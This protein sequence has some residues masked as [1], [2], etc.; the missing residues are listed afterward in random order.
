MMILVF[1]YI[2]MNAQSIVSTDPSN[3]NVV[4]EEYTGI[5]CG[6]CPD[7]H[8][9]AKA[10][11]DKFPGRVVVINIH[12]GSYANP[13]SGSGH[14]DFRTTY[15]PDLLSK[16]GVAGFP[17]GTINREVFT[18]G[19]Y[20]QQQPPT[21]EALSRGGWDPAGSVV[22]GQA[23]PV[24]VGAITSWNGSTRELT[25]DVELYY[26]DNADA[27]N[28]LNVVF[29]E[30]GYVG[31]QGGSAE[32]ANYVHN[33][34]LRHMLTGTWGETISTTT[35][36]TLVQKTYKY[37]VPS[38]YD[39]LE[40]DIAVFVTKGNN[41]FV[42]T[43]IKVPAKTPD[44]VLS[45]SGDMIAAKGNGESFTKEYTIRNNSNA[46]MTFDVVAEKSA[47]TPGDWDVAI[48]NNKTEITVAA[49][50]TGTFSVMITAGSSS[51]MGDAEIMVKE[52][53]AG[54]D[55]MTSKFSVISK[56]VKYLDIDLEAYS[57]YDVLSKARTGAAS[58]SVTDFVAVG[59]DLT[60][61]KV[62]IWNAAKAQGITTAAADLLNAY[63]NSNVG[64]VI[65]GS[66]AVPFLYFA[67]ANNALLGTLGISYASGNDI[68][69]TAF[70]LTGI[71]GDPITDGLSYPGLDL[72]ASQYYLQKLNIAN[73]Q[74]AFPILQVQGGTNE[75]VAVR[76]ETGMARAVVLGFNLPTLKLEAQQVELLK[77]SIDW[78][79][80][81]V[82]TKGPEISVNTS[83][84]EF[85]SVA[86]G[87]SKEESFKVTNEGDEDLVI[88]TMTFD[89]EEEGFAFVDLPTLPITI[90]PGAYIDITVAFSPVEEREYTDVVSIKSNAIS[91]EKSVTVNGIG[92]AGSNGAEISVNVEGIEFGSVNTGSSKEES[93]K[94]TND[95]NEN[96]VISSM[97]FDVE[98]AFAFV[99]M[100]SLPI[101]IEP[102]AFIDLTVAFTP[103]MDIDYT[104]EITIT[105]NAINGEKTVTLN[106][107]GTVS[108]VDENGNYFTGG[109][110]MNAGPNP[111]VQ[112]TQIRY[113]VTGNSQN[114]HIYIV[115]A[116]GKTVKTLVNSVVET[117]SYNVGFDGTN[118]SSG[119][120]FVVSVIDGKT[121]QMPV[122]LAK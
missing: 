80:G 31:Y 117:G 51:G 78:I 120:Y 21:G 118:L 99:G 122:V 68:Q 108:S 113:N 83:S 105:S 60:A 56:N 37:T 1:T 112:S 30:N 32:G 73:T 5:Y 61:L 33:K 35:K 4:L 71:A 49:G 91:G 93:F 69:K 88:T 40:C 26:T 45:T 74:K 102:G 94:I 81:S 70:T 101:T 9:R 53:I 8:V 96:L 103:T 64:V 57:M 38:E 106:G 18:G 2:D 6:Y 62:V 39:V 48:E 89:F 111:F 79:E 12:A 72:S 25:V 47:R 50:K 77:K 41:R 22:V 87:E 59:Q 65:V 10:L 85:G 15:G 27:T 90:E 43:G 100:P 97:E 23:S 20:Q 19:N 55:E 82:S 52:N 92:S 14:P 29:L 109:F 116:E 46:S 11:E 16:A 84:V 63:I 119:T 13:Q 66:V 7:G 54:A 36:G 34:I 114:V 42:Y 44:A 95:G 76:S 75:Y 110:S 67:D 17:A 107:A 115:N 104:S 58:L 121:I 3:R 28:K 98:D 24:N 86:P